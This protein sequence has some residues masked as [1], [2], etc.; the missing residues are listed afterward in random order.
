MIFISNTEY[1]PCASEV[2]GELAAVAFAR[3]TDYM[4]INGDSL[5][6]CDTECLTDAQ[7]AAI[8]SI[9]R[10]TSGLKLKFYDKLKALELL[11]KA[12]GLF[13]GSAMPSTQDNNLLD[14]IVAATGKEQDDAQT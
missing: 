9:E 2:L 10:T 3:A 5:G 8:S 7:A 4:A 1:K 14:A 13:D 12:M 6:I 11:G